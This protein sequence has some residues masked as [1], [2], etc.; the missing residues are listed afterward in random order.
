MNKNKPFK[1]GD[2]VKTDFYG[3][4]RDLIRIV[5]DCFRSP[6]KSESGWWVQTQDGLACDANWFRKV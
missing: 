3:R 1:P 4:Q 2:R 6:I 5:K